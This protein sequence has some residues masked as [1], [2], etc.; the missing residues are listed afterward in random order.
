MLKIPFGFLFLGFVWRKLTAKT[1][2][3]VSSPRSDPIFSRVIQGHHLA[4]PEPGQED[5]FLLDSFFPSA[6]PTP[7]HTHP[8]SFI[9][10]QHF[11][12]TCLPSL[13]FPGYSYRLI[14]LLGP[15]TCSLPTH[16]TSR[17]R[18]HFLGYSSGHLQHLQFKSPWWPRAHPEAPQ[19]SGAS[20]ALLRRQLRFS[21]L[22]YCSPPCKRYAFQGEMSYSL[23]DPL[24]FA[25]RLALCS[26]NVEQIPELLTN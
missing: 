23:L 10:S 12:P 24:Y 11:L 25:Q 16:C 21:P 5:P 14:A 2:A 26:V 4:V 17:D 7:A 22:V 15:Q 20:P 3:H 18:Q 19:S 6:S 1:S 9:V 8:L 13:H